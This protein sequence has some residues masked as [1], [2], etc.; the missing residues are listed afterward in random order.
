MLASDSLRCNPVQ[1]RSPSTD[2]PATQ[3]PLTP[4]SLVH[5]VSARRHRRD[6][7]TRS[8]RRSPVRELRTL[9][10]TSG[11]RK[12][13]QLGGRGTGTVAKAVGNRESLHPRQVRLSSTLQ[14]GLSQARP[15]R[16]PRPLPL[17]APGAVPELPS[18]VPVR[19]R[20]DGRQGQQRKFYWSPD[21]RIP[22]E[23]PKALPEAGRDLCTKC[24]WE[25]SAPS[26]LQFIHGNHP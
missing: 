6:S 15:R 20:G 11:G 25:P 8:G 5:K 23:V 4:Q 17:R 7:S 12:R 26:A 13:C 14:L 1:N 16:A 22:C 3:H 2:Q 9:G 18:P 24:L 10:L 19:A 21:I